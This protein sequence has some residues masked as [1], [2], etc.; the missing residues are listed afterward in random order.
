MKLSDWKET[1]RLART[2]A[3]KQ[4]QRKGRKKVIQQVS[5]CETDNVKEKKKE[6]TIS[7]SA[8][9]SSNRFFVHDVG[10]GSLQFQ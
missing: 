10:R 8:R 4:E 2:M 9:R 1:S 3:A 6:K 5:D 7:S